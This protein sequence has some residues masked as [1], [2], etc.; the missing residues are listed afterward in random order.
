[1]LGAANRLE[2]AHKIPT[3]RFVTFPPHTPA[4]IRT[5]STL[6]IPSHHP[7]VIRR[8]Q[9]LWLTVLPSDSPLHLPQAMTQQA[10]H[11]AT[12]P[13]ILYMTRL[14]LDSLPHRPQAMTRQARQVPASIWIKFCIWHLARA[15]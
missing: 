9:T 5:G 15:R 8:G 7:M 11:M 1:M 12:S 6:A 14:L 10:R 3:D 13:R 4:H 2:R